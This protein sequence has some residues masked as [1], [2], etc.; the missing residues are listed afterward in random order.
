MVLLKCMCTLA[1]KVLYMHLH[2]T[3]VLLKCREFNVNEEWLRQST[4]HYG[5]IKI[6]IFEDYDTSTVSSTFHYG[7]IK[8][9]LD[10]LEQNLHFNLHS[11]MVLLK[12]R[13]EGSKI[14]VYSNL[15]STMVLLK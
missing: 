14:V 6:T 10:A 8:M 15:H 5:S 2:S 7:S 9:V 1:T 11:T 12:F 13:I 3:M 4:F